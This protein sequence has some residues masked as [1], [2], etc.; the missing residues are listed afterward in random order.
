LTWL[1]FAFA[2]AVFY[3]LQGVWT[4]WIT[5][6]VSGPAA[7]WAIF[8]F[9]FPLLAAY[10]AFQ[11]VPPIAPAFWPALLTSASINVVS[12]YLYVSA[13]QKGDLGLTYP[14][15]A[16]TPV[17][18]LPVELVLLG[19]LPGLQGLG[20]ILLVA[21]G[22]Y[23]LNFSE[24]RAGLFAPFATVL[25]DPGARRMLAVALIWS[26]SAVLDKI[27]TVS[28]SPAFYGTLDSGLIALAFVPLVMRRGGGFRAALSRK[29]WWLLA[30]QGL[31]FALMFVVQMEAIQRTLAVYV[32]SIKRSG[33]I[34]TVLLGALLFGEPQLRERLGGAVVILAGVLLI[35][36]A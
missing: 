32:I 19:D 36:G 15:L 24:R 28:S 25:R 18:V 4:K 10:L 3:G 2:T 23:L 11:G 17:F 14:L 9:A 20:G 29:T 5:R 30:V 27:A 6:H 7:S 13:I 26:V 12:F 22:V 1:L 21:A 8:A 31:L 33:A 34:V 16:L 35:A